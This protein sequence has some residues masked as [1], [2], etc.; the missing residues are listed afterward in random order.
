MLL[1]FS[2]SYIIIHY[3]SIYIVISFMNILSSNNQMQMKDSY[4]LRLHLHCLQIL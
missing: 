1:S 2:L 4:R 3:V